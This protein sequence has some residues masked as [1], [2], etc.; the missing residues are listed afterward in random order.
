MPGRPVR[1]AIHAELLRRAKVELGETAN[2]LD[3]GEHWTASGRTL[4]EL[5]NILAK[6]L[7]ITVARETVRAAVYQDELEPGEAER[8][9]RLARARGAHHLQEDAKHIID[10]V[11]VN[12]DW[13][14]KAKLQADI[15]DRIA[16]S[17]N[18]EEWGETKQPLLTV[19]VESLHLDS[20]RRQVSPSQTDN[21][22]TDQ[23]ANAQTV[24]A[25]IVISSDTVSGASGST[26]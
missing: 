6:D 24:D 14:A 25:D 19:N 2:A 15:R 10:D 5:A 7:A 26:D 22:L 20:L 4:T 17:W 18:R 13:I 21:L 9:L 8:R 12:R 23:A 16:R 11:P 1:R 3:Y